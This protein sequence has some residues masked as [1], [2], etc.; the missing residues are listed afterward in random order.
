[1]AA[2]YRGIRRRGGC[3]DWDRCVT[4]AVTPDRRSQA[5]WT[6]VTLEGYLRAVV[7]VDLAASR[8]EP[9]ASSRVAAQHDH[10]PG[11]HGQDVAAHRLVLVGPDSY[12]PDPA[13][14]ERLHQRN[15]RQRRV[16]DGKVAGDGRD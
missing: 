11:F 10:S 8:F 2:A 6:P 16:D 4:S 13:L 15:R 12:D 14:G 7:L 5:S 9:G 3:P 1:M